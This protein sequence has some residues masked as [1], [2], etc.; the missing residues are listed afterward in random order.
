MSN[1]MFHVGIHRDAKV[2]TTRVGES[3]REHSTETRDVFRN[4]ALERKLDHEQ[5]T[6]GA[7]WRCVALVRSCVTS[8]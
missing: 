3:V 8:C 4:G 6:R 2:L 5:R 7:V 1:H